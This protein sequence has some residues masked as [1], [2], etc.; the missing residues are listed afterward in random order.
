[1]D[2]ADS[3]DVCV[4]AFVR[5]RPLALCT[6]ALGVNKLI[7]LFWRDAKGDDGT[8]CTLDCGIYREK[9]IGQLV[10]C[11]WRPMRFIMRP[12]R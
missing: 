9:I 8:R 10:S 3:P 1:M 4:K 5:S 11:T 12:F 2:Q 6:R 7:F